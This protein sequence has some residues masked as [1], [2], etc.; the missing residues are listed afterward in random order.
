MERSLETACSKPAAAHAG[1]VLIVDDDPVVAGMLGVSLSVAGH[2]IIEI[3][4]GE[5]A[6]F[7]LADQAD[8]QRPDLVILDKLQESHDHQPSACLVV[9]NRHAHRRRQS[10]RAHP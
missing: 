5:E 6:L 10:L 9:D 3:Y 7:W 1:R 4:S 8:G 2:E